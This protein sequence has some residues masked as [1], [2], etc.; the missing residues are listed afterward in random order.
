MID[1]RTKSKLLKELEKNGNIFLSCLKV[2]VDRSTY[3]RWLSADK[4]FEKLANQAVRRGRENNCDIAKHVL[5]TLVKEKN[6]R[7]VEY[8]LSHNDP[9]YKSKHTSNVIIVHK[10]VSSLPPSDVKTLE[11]VLDEEEKSAHERGL[12]VQKTLTMF[13]NPIPLKL[14]GSPIP[15]DE[16]PGYEAYIRDWQKQR[17][18][19]INKERFKRGLPPTSIL[20]H[21]PDDETMAGEKFTTGIKD[22]GLKKD[23]STEGPPENQVI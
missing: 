23:G 17:R 22:L 13:G 4:E 18:Q 11:D 5:M 15:I 20:W 7:A 8:V 2:G 6:M 10:K 16:L 1:D 3:Y 9:S 21:H 12:E 19:A 14:D